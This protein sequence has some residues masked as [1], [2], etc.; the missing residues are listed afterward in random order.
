VQPKAKIVCQAASGIDDSH[1][2]GPI[3][4]GPGNVVDELAVLITKG[5]RSLTIGSNNHFEVGC[6]V[7]S[8][9]IGDG[10][11]IGVRAVLGPDSC[12]G[13]GCII[14]P[15]VFIPPGTVLADDTIVY[16]SLRDQQ[17][18]ERT[19]EVTFSAALFR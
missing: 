3:V 18:V 4:I 14:G 11:V 7:E 2:G 12:L 6:R 9:F 5:G 1:G 10:N 13:S 19:A 8:R 15:G 16:T 17:V